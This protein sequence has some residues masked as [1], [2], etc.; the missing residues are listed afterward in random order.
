M[1][2]FS[3]TDFF[4][5]TEYQIVCL[6]NDFMFFSSVSGA[7]K[8]GNEKHY[9]WNLKNWSECILKFEQKKR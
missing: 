6:T 7:R 1:F 2:K 5:S 9:F 8:P 3:L 4:Q